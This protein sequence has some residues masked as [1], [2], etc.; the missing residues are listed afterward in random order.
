MNYE[1]NT[2]YVRA[3][4]GDEPPVQI[5]EKG[6]YTGTIIMAKEVRAGTGSRGI[7]ITYKD[8]SGAI[9][10][11]NTFYTHNKDMEPLF[12]NNLIHSLMFILKL[13]SLVPRLGTYPKWD[14]EQKKEIQV[15]G[16][17][18]PDLVGKPIGVILQPEE[19]ENRDGDIK[20]AMK[21]RGFFDPV[22]RMTAT[23]MLNN[24]EE[25][26]RVEQWVANMKPVKELKKK[27]QQAAQRQAEKFVDDDLSDIPF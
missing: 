21:I 13:R 22:T 19:Y 23:E 8:D 2:R 15:Q 4:E 17:V 11:G 6:A 1:L 12:G 20:L 7:A 27:P 18:F 25:P 16:T 14:Y 26:K 10:R 24:E 3:A 9:V 5:T